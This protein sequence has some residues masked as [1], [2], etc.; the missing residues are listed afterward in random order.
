MEEYTLNELQKMVAKQVMDRGGYWP[1]EMILRHAFKELSE[2]GEAMDFESGALK[3]KPE[4]KIPKISHELADVFYAIICFANTRGIDLA[5]AL[6][7][8]A[9]INQERDKDRFK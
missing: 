2:V 4:Q 9:G 6:I 5:Q 3:P 8:K 1:D 7:E